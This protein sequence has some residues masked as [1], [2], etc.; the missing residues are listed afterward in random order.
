MKTL[1]LAFF[2]IATLF[3]TF[4]FA[5]DPEPKK[6]INW[7]SFEKAEE[8]AKTNPK[9]L[10]V[11]LYT[12]WCH[13]CKVM[14]KETY[15]KAEIIDYINKNYYAVKF[16][17]EQKE[18]I[19]FKGQTFEY[20]D[21]YQRRGTHQLASAILQGKGGY[22]STAFF[23]KDFNLIQVVPGYQKAPQMEKLLNYMGPAK[24]T[25]TKW[26]DFEKTFVSKLK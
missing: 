15:T 20:V 5:N 3:S 24:Y 17:A 19:N 13:W 16:N 9:P 22:P 14:D 18:A 1:K 6:E 2:L 10:L 7:I 12:D 25:D 8:L 21:R 23:D 4:T 26:E 11:D